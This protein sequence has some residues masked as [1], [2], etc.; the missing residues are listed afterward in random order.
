MHVQPG[1]GFLEFCKETIVLET[2][3]DTC[4]SAKVIS[5]I[6]EVAQWLVDGFISI[7]RQMSN[8]NPMFL[9]ILELFIFVAVTL[10]SDPLGL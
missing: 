5:Q 8:S 10:Y 6:C 9:L 4:F 7:R 2:Q 1:Q 3:R